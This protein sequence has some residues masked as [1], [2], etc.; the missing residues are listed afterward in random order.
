MMQLTPLET[1]MAPPNIHGCVCSC[2]LFSCSIGTFLGSMLAVWIQLIDP[3]HG[4]IRLVHAQ[5]YSSM[6]DIG[7][8]Y[9]WAKPCTESCSL[10][11]GEV[12]SSKTHSQQEL[13]LQRVHFPIAML[14]C[15]SVKE[16]KGL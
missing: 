15:G 11:S 4:T 3:S 7:R 5:Q 10:T 6:S 14:V 1:S 2:R 13:H 16:Y 9:C 8:S 12:P